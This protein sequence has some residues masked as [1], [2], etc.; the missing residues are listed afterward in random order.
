MGLPRGPPGSGP[1]GASGSGLER[2]ERNITMSRTNENSEVESVP[3]N[4]H[5]VIERLVATDLENAPTA[6]PDPDSQT[7]PRTP[8]PSI[9]A[10]IF[11]GPHRTNASELNRENVTERRRATSPLAEPTAT[12]SLQDQLIQLR[13]D[14]ESAELK[15]RAAAAEEATAISQRN[16]KRLALES[17]DLDRQYLDH[18][19]R[20]PSPHG[21]RSSSH[22]S[23]TASPRHRQEAGRQPSPPLTGATD[24]VTVLLHLE[25]QRREDR[26]E[27][28]EREERMEARFRAMLP[29]APPAASGFTPNKGLSAIPPFTGEDG[30]ELRPWL[31][32]FQSTAEILELP[33]HATARE[34][35]LKL[36]GRALKLYNLRFLPETKITVAEVVTF[37]STEFIKK[38]QGAILFGEYF[39]YKRKAGSAGQDVQRDLNNAWQAMR[40]DGIPVDNMSPD[41]GRYYLYQLALTSTQSAQFLASLSSTTLASDDYLRSLTPPP[42]GDRRTSLA[43][44]QNSEARTE[45]FRLRVTLIEAFLTHD[46]GDLGH[47]RGARA[48]VTAGTPNDTTGTVPS[49]GTTS[50]PPPLAAT[51]VPGG[52]LKEARVRALQAQWELRGHNTTPPLYHGKNDTHLAANSATFAERKAR[53]ACFCCREDQLVPGQLHWECKFHG[54]DASETSRRARVQGSGFHKW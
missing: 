50:P 34:L 30:Q 5:D 52:S 53:R 36:A 7:V 33:E 21:S 31:H 32:L 35:R 24:L 48:A 42:A 1:R 20:Y 22:G 40:D 3:D 18:D 25:T 8:A 12:S 6:F 2:R 49:Q 47:G 26:R 41:E 4:S 45:C 37:L 15:A 16:T 23:S 9:L 44:P 38:Y 39:Q 28:A 19:H 13:F 11:G 43:R 51:S 27:A 10:Y 14:T 17:R 46:N 29:T 54:K